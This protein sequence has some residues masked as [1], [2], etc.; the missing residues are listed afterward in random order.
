MD[1]PGDILR[2]R[3]TDKGL[4]AIAIPAFMRNIANTIAGNSFADLGQINRQLHL[5][6]WDE[7]ELDYYTLQLILACLESEDL[8]SLRHFKMEEY[9]E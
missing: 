2:K 9:N 1:Q 3:L 4:G 6:G 7:F 5:S 8:M